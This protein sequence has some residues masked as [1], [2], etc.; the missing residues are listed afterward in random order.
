MLQQPEIY[1]N[2]NPPDLD[3]DLDPAITRDFVAQ[4]M[5]FGPSDILHHCTRSL[6]LAVKGL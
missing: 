2:L 1:L 3:L 4:Q 6:V 5:T